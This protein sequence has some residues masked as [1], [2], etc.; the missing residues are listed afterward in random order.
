MFNVS[1]K[2]ISEIVAFIVPSVCNRN[3]I[4]TAKFQKL[5]PCTW[6]CRY[7]L[8]FATF[9]PNAFPQVSQHS[10]QQTLY[11]V[12]SQNLLIIKWWLT[13]KGGACLSLSWLL[14]TPQLPPHCLF[15]MN[16][17]K[18]PQFRLVSN[19]WVLHRRKQKPDT[20]KWISSYAIQL[21]V[22]GV[23]YRR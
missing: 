4:S 11:H 15:D 20:R 3:N 6:R 9:P 18:S 13:Q 10:Q 5:P 7:F 17:R 16:K 2:A 1:T 8:P 21:L 22:G 19:V 12:S 23:E 14:L